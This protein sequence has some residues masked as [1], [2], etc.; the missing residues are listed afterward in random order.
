MRMKGGMETNHLKIKYNKTT[1]SKR[2][3]CFEQ[4]AQE[5]A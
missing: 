3:C 5:N 4:H 1:Q 2:G